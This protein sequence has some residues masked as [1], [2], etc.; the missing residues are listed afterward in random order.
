MDFELDSML[1]DSMLRE[2]DAIYF[3][4]HI[5]VDIRKELCYHLVIESEIRRAS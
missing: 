3:I 2:D 1:L 5:H 4:V